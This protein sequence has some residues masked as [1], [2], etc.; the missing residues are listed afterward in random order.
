MKLRNLTSQVR[1]L[2]AFFAASAACAHYA[3]ADAIYN[4]SMDTSGLVGNPA[5]PFYLDFQFNDGS[6]TNDGNNTVTVGGFNVAGVGAASPS[7][8]GTGDLG[9]SIVLTDSDSSTKCSSTSRQ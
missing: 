9:S 5:A 7:G 3:Y 6:G 8:G 2:A 1:I 4:V